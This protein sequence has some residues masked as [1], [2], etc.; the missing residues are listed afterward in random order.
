MMRTHTSDKLSRVREGARV[1]VAGWLASKRDQGSLL[2]LLLRDGWGEIQ[3]TLK[4]GRVDDSMLEKAR[5]IPMHSAV[6]VVGH[7]KRDPR[8]PNGVEVLPTRLVVVSKARRQPPFSIYGGELPGIDKR[9]D[10][11]AVD[12]RRVKAQAIFRVRHTAIQAV[13]EFFNKNKFLEVQTPKI[14]SSATEGGAALFP[15]LYFDKEAFLAQS[16]Q[17]YK[18]Q[19]VMAFDRVYEVGPIFRAEPSR[20]LKHLSETISIDAEAAFMDY[21]DVMKVLERL[22]RHV[23]ANVVRKNPEELNILRV[24]LKQPR[25]PFKRLTYE[26]C[27]DLL[28][29]HGVSKSFGDDLDSSDLRILGE[30]VNDFFFITDWPTRLKPFYIKPKRVRPDASE[31][32]DLMFKDLELSSGGTRVNSRRLL[33]KRLRE[34]GLKPKSFE[35]HLRVFDYGMPPHA[36]FG[37]GLDRLMMVLTGQENIREVTLYPRDIKRL[38]P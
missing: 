24:E 33:V 29:K 11:R 21:E 3:V 8:A 16:P 37:L 31:S 27:L 36:G 13:R 1:K 2:F 17:L 7:A 34:Q 32:F 28:D 9:L 5:R 25:I 10:V 18:E 4:K 20:T 19:L 22:V 6:Y 26:D 14:I 30:E 38:A 35:Y 23:I 15:L 12:L